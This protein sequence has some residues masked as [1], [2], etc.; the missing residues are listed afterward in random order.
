MTRPVRLEVISTGWSAT[1]QDLGR[2]D[3]ER[4]GVPT[5]GAADQH[6][7]GVANVLVGNDRR[8]PL[9][10]IMGGQFSVVPS[11][12]VLVAVTGAPAPVTVDARPAPS[13]SPVVVPA[14]EEL[15]IG[16]AQHGMRTYLAVNGAIQT[17]TFLGSAAPD[18][19]MGFG[20][21]V[22]RG[23]AIE[24]RSAFRGLRQGLPGGPLFRFPVPVP[25]LGP[26][27]WTLDVVAARETAT[28]PGITE[29]LADSTYVVTPRSDH[30]GLR[31]S[32][33]VAHPVDRAEIVSH[34]VPVGA[35]EIP[36]AD[37]L[38]LLGRYRS[39]TAGYPIAGL[40]TRTSLSLAGQAE[41]GRELRF[42]W[43]DRAE[44]VEAHV[45]RER[46]VR[47]LELA[48]ARALEASGVSVPATRRP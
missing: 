19:R 4:L 28:I 38:I 30:V 25:G 16:A 41:P 20:Q 14:G 23:T 5:G 47:E 13:W 32:G 31:L 36:P 11:S 12:D 35:I 45:R 7:A 27:P 21:A 40:L 46:A 1:Y 43:V 34:G 2:T 37:E 39:L 26:G 9:L 6:S 10:E 22:A 3:A 18:P 15:R 48:V 42:R 24:V 33:P 29:L 44:A 8:A 17:E